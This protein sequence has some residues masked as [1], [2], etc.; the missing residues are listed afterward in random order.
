MNEFFS[1]HFQYR[2]DHKLASMTPAFSPDGRILA[3]GVNGPEIR[4]WNAETCVEQEPLSLGTAKARY[5][6]FSPDGAML[7]VATWKSRTVTVYDWRSARPIAV[8]DGHCGEINILAFS[9]DGSKLV[10]ADSTSQICIWE[11]AS[12]KARARWRANAA[13]V[14]RSCTHQTADYLRPRATSMTRSDSGI[15]PAESLGEFSTLVRPE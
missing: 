11:L 3:I 12:Q 2:A 4:L 15:L 6:V 14:W 1:E 5:G 7:A 9:P 8:L 13:G 10:A